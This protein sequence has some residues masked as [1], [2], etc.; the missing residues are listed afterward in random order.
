MPVRE[1]R[2]SKISVTIVKSHCKKDSGWLV[3]KMIS[4]KRTENT[5][6]SRSRMRLPPT[7]I[8]ALF[9]PLNRVFNPPDNITP[10]QGIVIFSYYRFLCLVFKYPHQHRKYSRQNQDKFKEVVRLQRTEDRKQKYFLNII[11]EIKINCGYK[12]NIPFREGRASTRLGSSQIVP[13]FLPGA[14]SFQL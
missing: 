11:I 2:R 3:T 12:S 13:T 4:S 9:S 6:R 1:L 7:L 10:V 8:K 5:S 14:M